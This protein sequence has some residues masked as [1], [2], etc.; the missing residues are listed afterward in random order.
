MKVKPILETILF[1]KS[2]FSILWVC[3]TSSNASP[4]LVTEVN[5]RIL[6]AVLYGARA[7]LRRGGPFAKVQRYF[8]TCWWWGGGRAVS[9][10]RTARHRWGREVK[11]TNPWIQRWGQW[12]FSGSDRWGSSRE[13]QWR[14]RR[15]LAT[16]M[17]WLPISQVLPSVVL[18]GSKE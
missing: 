4:Q 1:I 15:K 16:E 6:W 10:G 8:A 5:A 12:Q 17:W 18:T 9:R 14:R 2:K 11:G 13:W 7:L 3:N